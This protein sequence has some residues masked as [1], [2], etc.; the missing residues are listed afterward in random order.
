MAEV[1][2]DQRELVLAPNEFCYVQNSSDGGITTA[3]GPLN[4]NL[5]QNESCV[6]F[7]SVTKKFIQ[8]NGPVKPI[9]QMVTAP[10]GWYIVLFN[11][12]AKK[13]DAGKK[14]VSDNLEIGKKIIIPGPT[15]FA[16]WPGQMAQVIEGHRL[17]SNEYLITE[18]Y[19]ANDAKTNWT[20]STLQANLQT[21]TNTTS[22]GEPT[23]APQ[24]VEPSVSII[25]NIE[26]P[27]DLANGKRYIIKGTEI[28][29]YIPP[30][31]VKVV[32]DDE[33][34]TYIR[35]AISLEK[36]EYAILLDENGEKEYAY[37]PKVVFPQ[38]TQEF[39]KHNN[40]SKYKA[41]ELDARKGIHIKVIEQY[42]ESE[43]THPV[44]E[45]LF[46]YGDG[47]IYMPRKEHSIIKY[48]KKETHHAIAI[49]KGEGWYVLNRKTSEVSVIRG[50]RMFL[51]DPREQVITRRILSEKEVELYYP[52]NKTAAEVNKQL[53]N[54][55]QG[56]V[57][58]LSMS[59][60]LSN[61]AMSVNAMYSTNAHTDEK[62]L[63]KKKLTATENFG[64]DS[65]ERSNDFSKPRQITLDSKY[66]G[67]VG[68]YVWTGYAV[69]VINK[70]GAGRVEV[71]PCPFLLE[72][73]ESLE[74]MTLSTGKPK[75]TD[76]LLSTVFLRIKGNKVSDL[77]EAETSDMVTVKIKLSYR[78]NFLE[79]Q[80]DDRTKW[81]SVENYVKFLCDH[82]RSIIKAAV[83]KVSILDL[84][85]NL[86]DII[87]DTLL[88]KKLE[89]SG[90]RNGL[91]FEENNMMVYD[92]EV[93]KMEIANEST[94]DMICKTE[95][96]IINHVLTLKEKE[97]TASITTLLT[98]YDLAILDSLLKVEAAKYSNRMEILEMET[99]AKE[100]ENKKAALQLELEQAEHDQKLRQRQDIEKIT[101]DRLKAQTEASKA[102]ASA[103]SPSLIQAINNLKNAQL[104][105]SLS[106]NFANL[107]ILE[108]K[109]VLATASRFLDS[110][111]EEFMKD[112]KQLYKPT[113]TETDTETDTEKE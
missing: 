13:P 83:K 82:A 44:G 56:D 65:F 103:F 57:S 77:I 24:K 55:V 22:E 20:K 101:M 9:Q 26:A 80:P 105:E 7:D 3:V 87:R 59:N 34:K 38:P 86:A 98:N 49:P 28:A 92:V 11:P 62:P 89:E 60:F 10:S 52:G 23:D 69:K 100:A 2:R 25:N 72:Y 71:G 32:F 41:I 81:F 96:N 93:L 68:I 107:S 45:E 111:P 110:V 53:R 36:L 88:G 61:N 106:K 30:S 21:M 16:L 112:M 14:N 73:D 6:I 39:I 95:R 54:E 29:F 67:A 47:L 75:T 64:G 108:G 85:S 8:A 4:V 70:T 90:K 48:G 104:T 40:S 37:G 1:V 27:S 35:Q 50:P 5:G 63:V 12:S 46:I 79:N 18:I 97:D 76:N 109:G 15:S 94:R 113:N 42:T 19:D 58:A 84:N 43:I 91:F 33:N 102:I 66:Q 31:G 74:P 51:P 17:R 99:K 78:V